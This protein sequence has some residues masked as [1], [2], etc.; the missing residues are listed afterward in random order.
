[1]D[2]GERHADQLYLHPRLPQQPLGLDW[3]VQGDVMARQGV[4]QPLPSGLSILGPTGAGHRL[5]SS[6]RDWQ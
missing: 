4:S 2:H 1:M 5:K 6:P 3:T